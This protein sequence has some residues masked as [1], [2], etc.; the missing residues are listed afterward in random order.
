MWTSGNK[1]KTVEYLERGNLLVV[2]PGAI[3]WK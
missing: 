3:S 1:L 2:K